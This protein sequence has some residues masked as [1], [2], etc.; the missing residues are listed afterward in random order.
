MPLARLK[1]FRATRG[2]Y[3]T[4]VAAP[5]M[6]AALEAWGAK[7]SLFKDKVAREIHD[8]K[9]VKLATSKPRVVFRRI[10]GSNAKFEPDV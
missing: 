1:V 9:L 2:F 10:V 8:P 3:D 4:V 7:P 5:S 6:K